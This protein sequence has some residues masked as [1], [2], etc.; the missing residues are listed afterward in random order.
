[1]FHG[2]FHG[3][4]EGEDNQK[5][6]SLTRSIRKF[7]VTLFGVAG[8]NGKG[9]GKGGEHGVSEMELVRGA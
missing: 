3:G 6:A 4:R 1:M 9:V 8:E 5:R 2:G 7:G